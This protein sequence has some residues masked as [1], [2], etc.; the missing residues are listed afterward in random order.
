MLK[1]TR[2]L[3]NLA[4]FGCL[5]AA[6]SPDA[7][8][9]ESAASETS[10]TGELTDEDVIA[11]LEAS[12]AV[13]SYS[14]NP[15]DEPEE[16]ELTADGGG[17]GTQA[18]CR[19]LDAEGTSGLVCQVGD[20]TCAVW[21]TED[22]L[23]GGC[24]RN[25][26]SS[27]EDAVSENENPQVIAV[28][29]GEVAGANGCRALDAEGTSGLV[30]KVGNLTCAVWTTEDGLRGGCASGTSSSTED[31]AAEAAQLI[32]AG[33]V[34]QANGCRPI[35]TD[36]GTPGVVCTVGDLTCAVWRDDEGDL[37]A[38]CN[39]G[40]PLA[41][42]KDGGSDEPASF[43][44]ALESD[45]T[46][47]M[48]CLLGERN[49]TVWPDSEGVLRGG[50]EVYGDNYRDDYSDCRPLKTD[51]GETGVTC[52]LDSLTCAAWTDVDGDVHGGC[53]KTL[54]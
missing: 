31:S 48:T 25:T 23:R 8:T 26:S 13:Q 43:C 49:C 52:E 45:G 3:L 7:D 4:I 33:E 1:Q 24:S 10:R 27:D 21:T 2:V 12:G 17:N 35:E 28:D 20:L 19:A 37:R 32:A 16:P 5:T 44:Q 14:A 50:C 29:R 47:G 46:A 38:G 6:C 51:D 42:G 39:G 18:G 36:D 15:P 40:D 11:L 30:C 53:T 54:R 22:G 9:S 34:S 41:D